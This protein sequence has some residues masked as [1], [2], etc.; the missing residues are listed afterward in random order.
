[1]SVEIQPC[2][3]PL[4]HS[5][6]A[7]QPLS[8]AL[9]RSSLRQESPSLSSPP[10][11]HPPCRL[12]AFNW[13]LTPLYFTVSIISLSLLSSLSIY[14]LKPIS[15]LPYCRHEHFF[16]FSFFKEGIS[17]S[18]HFLHIKMWN[19]FWH[20]AG[21]RVELAICPYLSPLSSPHSPPLS[22]SLS[23]SHVSPMTVHEAARPPH[24]LSSPISQDKGLPVVNYI[25]IT[26]IKKEHCPISC[27]L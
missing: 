26:I 15:S 21:N 10:A 8:P 19:S 23:L 17:E 6:L 5:L 27:S 22:Q 14:L 11:M 2:E 16:F 13:V 25:F 12:P 18:K 20:W 3:W 4:G 7:C 24:C 9:G 1:M